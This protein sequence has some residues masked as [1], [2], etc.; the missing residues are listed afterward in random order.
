[1]VAASWQ[2]T[3]AQTEISIF[4]P[5]TTSPNSPGKDWKWKPFGT[6]VTVKIKM[7]KVDQRYNAVFCNFTLNIIK[8][9]HK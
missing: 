9:G 7:R 4:K 5:Q 3:C 2:S 6:T 1:M 8:V